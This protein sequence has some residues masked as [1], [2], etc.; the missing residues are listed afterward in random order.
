M[1][2]IEKLFDEIGKDKAAFLDALIVVFHRRRGIFSCFLCQ[3]IIFLRSHHKGMKAGGVNGHMGVVHADNGENVSH[4]FKDVMHCFLLDNGRLRLLHDE[5]VFP[6][7]GKGALVEI[8]GKE[9][10][11]RSDGIGAVYDDD[12]VEIF[13]GLCKGNAVP[14]MDV[15]F[16]RGIVQ[17]SGNGG[18][19]FL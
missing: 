7:S 18:E 15:K 12:I 5:S 10:F 6:E 19:I 17:H 3:R 4:G 8:A 16:F 1:S 2:L 14:H 11:S 9:S 13:H